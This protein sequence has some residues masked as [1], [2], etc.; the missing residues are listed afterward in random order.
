[1]RSFSFLLFA[2]FS[3]VIFQ[4][5]SKDQ[6]GFN[7]ESVEK[8]YGKFK[9]SSIKDR[10]FKHS[11]IKAI[12]TNLPEN[13]FDVTAQGKSVE[14]KEIYTVKYG[15]GPVKILLWSQMHGDEPT[16]TMAMMDVF[17]FLKDNNNQTDFKEAL[18]DQ[19]SIYFLP[20]LNPDGADKFQR[21]NALGI[22]LNRDAVRL[23]SPES[24]LLKKVYDDIQ[25]DWAFNLHDQNR[26]YSAGI[27]KNPASISF[28]APA[29]NYKKDMNAERS[30]AMKLIGMLNETVQ[31]FLPGHV[32]KYNDDFEPRAFGDN[33]QK[34]GARTVLIET[35][36]LN[37]DREKQT[38]RKI[39]FLTLLSAFDIISGGD[40]GSAS[41]KAYNDIPM[42]E[43]DA[44]HEVIVRKATISKGG[45]SFEMDIA[46]RFDEIGYNRNKNYHLQNSISD[47]GDLRTAHGYVEIDA[48]GMKAVP[49]KV[50][51]TLIGSMDEL[52]DIDPVELLSQGITYL[53][54]EET[55]A[56][57]FT[58]KFPLE[59]IAPGQ[60]PD[61]TL[62][63]G[64]NPA[65]AFQ[66]DGKTAMVA[67]N[68]HVLNLKKDK[69]LIRNRFNET[70]SSL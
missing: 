45:N 49:G 12:V 41:I 22:D 28:L 56:P 4:G 35:G 23:Q 69:E 51:S 65:L 29:Y 57:Q 10:R 68:G 60:S 6:S 38:L 16:A 8:D 70:L 59:L 1:M 18:R 9:E 30:D 46:M 48:E 25:P 47:M 50:Y 66:K 54:V 40:Y 17:N 5:C 67:V 3:I 36:G 42:N 37:D 64:H 21:R 53:V 15:D 7:V 58:E 63:I 43:S 32:A 39:N 2:V 19:L 31:E 62:D 24:K 11:D 61:V 55:P 13:Q 26:Y 14:G 34:W 52:A 27:S 44:F 20:M 33:M